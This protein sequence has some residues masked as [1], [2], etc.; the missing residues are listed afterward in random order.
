[1]SLR[2]RI[3]MLVGLALLPPVGLLTYDTI[4][5]R[6]R[7]RADLLHDARQ[8]AMLIAGQ[9]DTIIQGAQ[10]LSWA[11][12]HQTQVIR[13]DLARCSELL[14][15]VVSEVP[16]YRAA[17]VTDRAGLVVCSWP[18]VDGVSLGDR[19]Y[20]K[21]ALGQPEFVIGPLLLKGRVTEATALP[22]ARRYGADNDGDDGGVIVLGIDV[23]LLAKRFQE[24][25]EWK[26][27][28]LSIL[29][30]EGTIILRVP[31]HAE[32]VGKKVSADGMSQLGTEPPAPS[33]GATGSGAPP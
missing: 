31:G 2:N 17:I 21:R 18:R 32:S 6:R 13:A 29:D 14:Q 26:N 10:R 20:I 1:M 28:Y 33:N 24:R 30:R 15:S 19:D 25:Y 27:R 9:M 16:L 22:L 12:S 11:L 4:D 7:E 5:T 3:A 23:D 8:E